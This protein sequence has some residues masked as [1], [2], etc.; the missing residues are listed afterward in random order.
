MN[1]PRLAVSREEQDSIYQFRY[2]VFAET[3]GRGDL[4]GLDHGRKML[5]DGLDAVSSHYYLGE[6]CCPIASV[7]VSPLDLT[8]ISPDM[9]EFLAVERLQEAVDLRRM[10][11]V[12]WLL[13]DPA[14]S[15]STLVPMLLGSCY[16]RLLKSGIDVL[17]T[18]C[19]PGLVS[20]YERL[21]LEQ[22]SYAGQIK[23]V[24]LR[25]PLMLVMKD[26]A[27]LKAVR[28]PLFRILAKSGL[29]G[30]PD[31]TR[32]RLE[33]I[34]DRFQASQILVNDELW[35]EGGVKFVE[36][37]A[38]KLFDGIG[39]DSLRQIM[40]LASVISCRSGEVITRRGETSD[41]MFLI[42]SGAFEALMNDSG[43]ARQLGAGDLFGELEH[44][45]KVPRRENVISTSEGHIAALKAERIFDWMEKNPEAGVKLAVNLARLVAGR[46]A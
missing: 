15:G 42:V 8:A 17:L 33:P 3:L 1:E 29:E 18:I 16:D 5:C 22:Y 14:Y 35:I 38:P 27:R 43:H 31:E 7:T 37:P 26:G 25:C 34:I 12:N 40:K 45:S 20:F 19:R 28:S 32:L 2:R 4:D 13:V 39:D 9:A 23:G 6:E 10:C 41:D 21:G 11:F 36:R 46:F 44:L 24:G 30:L